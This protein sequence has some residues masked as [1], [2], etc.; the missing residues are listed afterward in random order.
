MDMGDA[1]I[2]V[3]QH[4]A[5]ITVLPS[6]DPPLSIEVTADTIHSELSQLESACMW[7]VRE[8]APSEFAITFPSAEL[9]RA[10]SW[11]E[12]TTL[13]LHNIKV[14][15]RPSCVDPETVASLSFVW[16]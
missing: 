3:L 7:N 2:F 10:L 15:V 16:V 8:V 1:E 9:L 5:V 14:A 11:S 6:Q 12:T 13:L 4:I